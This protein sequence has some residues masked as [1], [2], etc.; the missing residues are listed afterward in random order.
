MFLEFHT[1]LSISYENRFL[2]GSLIVVFHYAAL[3][4]FPMSYIFFPSK[5][6]DS[7]HSVSHFSTLFPM[8]KPADFYISY[9]PY[10]LF[11]YDP[12]IDFSNSSETDPIS[13]P[14]LIDFRNC[15]THQRSL[16]VFPMI[17]RRTTVSQT[18]GSIKLS[19]CN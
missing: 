2:F 4:L 15:S 12:F 14:K 9:F 18:R 16:S 1:F 13:R 10:S 6:F 8:Q 7:F 3:V 19:I 17:P 5:S 11:T